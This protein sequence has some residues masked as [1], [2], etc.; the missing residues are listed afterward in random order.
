[1]IE[2]ITQ[3]NIKVIQNLCQY[4]MDQI[5]IKHLYN[6][7]FIKLNTKIASNLNI[8]MQNIQLFEEKHQSLFL[9]SANRKYI[10]RSY[11]C[12]LNHQ[13]NF[14][15]NLNHLTTTKDFYPSKV[16]TATKK[17]LHKNH[18]PKQYFKGDCS[19][20]T[21]QIIYPKITLITNTSECKNIDKINIKHLFSYQA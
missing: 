17:I 7:T 2:L 5:F 21:I 16:K 3:Q 6:Y 18:F 8:L 9:L 20:D 4:L 15:E 11:F 19:F 12:F 1:M 10:K 14:G 13:A